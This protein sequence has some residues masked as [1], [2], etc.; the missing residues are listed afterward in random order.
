[1]VE[2]RFLRVKLS[3]LVPYEN[4]PRN[5]PEEAVDAVRESVL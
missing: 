3:E 2:K 5:I 4:N 1:M